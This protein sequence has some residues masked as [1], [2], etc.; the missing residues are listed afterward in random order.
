MV[1]SKNGK[2][3]YGELRINRDMTIE[4]IITNLVKAGVLLP[5]EPA[6]ISYRKVLQGY[7]TLTL[8][9][10]LVVS[11]QLRDTAEGSE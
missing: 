8:I 5:E 10:T 2:D 1:F 7:D 6:A 3:E 11:H 9:K 4:V